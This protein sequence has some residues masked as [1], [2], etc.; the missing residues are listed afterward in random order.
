MGIKFTKMLPRTRMLGVA[1]I[2]GDN[3]LVVLLLS[4]GWPLSLHMHSR[5]TINES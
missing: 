3:L 4:I 5:K 2:S 1:V